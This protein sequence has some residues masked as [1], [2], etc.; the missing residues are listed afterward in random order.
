MRRPCQ[1]IGTRVNVLSVGRPT[2]LDDLVKRRILD[3]LRAGV[4]RTAAAHGARVGYSTLK[5]WLAD[6]RDG[7]EPFSTFLA[8]VHEAEAGAE[9]LVGNAMFKSACEGHVGAQSFWLERRRNADW[10]KRDVV[11]H[12]A[13]DGVEQTDASDL[14]TARSVLAALESRK[15]AV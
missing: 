6:G 5:G 3:A 12:E 7:V 4:S 15:V 10:G 8:D 14:E 9:R 13:G 2:K 1:R 11:T